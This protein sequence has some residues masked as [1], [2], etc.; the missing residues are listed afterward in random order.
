MA[1]GSLTGCETL[2]LSGLSLPLH[3]MGTASFCRDFTL[4]SSRA[5]HGAVLPAWAGA[6]KRTRDSWM[7]QPRRK[8]RHEDVAGV[9]WDVTPPCPGLLRTRVLKA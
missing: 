4:G 9:G 7:R 1:W 2:C 8:D 3:G 6:V 5:P